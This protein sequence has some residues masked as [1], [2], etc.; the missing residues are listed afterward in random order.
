MFL[1]LIHIE[2]RATVWEHQVNISGVVALLPVDMDSYSLKNS[3]IKL[4]L[5]I[6]VMFIHLI[7]GSDPDFHFY[8]PSVTTTLKLNALFVFSL[9][10]WTA[11]I[12]AFAVLTSERPSGAI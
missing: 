2:F 9:T 7:R 3:C 1:V 4:F 5:P 10:L 11:L 8:F 6:L 12:P